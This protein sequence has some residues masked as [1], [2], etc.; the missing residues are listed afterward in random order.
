MKK[1]MFT[2]LCTLSIAGL[3]A[4]PS[5]PAHAAENAHKL[6]SIS[7]NVST[8]KITLDSNTD[9]DDILERLEA[10]GIEFNWQSLNTG[11]S[12]GIVQIIQNCTPDNTLPDD[13]D[14][15]SG[16]SNDEDT[17]PDN[18]NGG[19]TQ[20]DNGGSDNDN[21]GDTQPDKDD[22]NN[23]GNN[24]QPDNGGSNNGN[25]D[26]SS[27]NTGSEL[28]ALAA[29]VADIVNSERANAGLPALEF[30]FQLSSAAQ[31]RAEEIETYFSHTRPDGSSFSSVLAEHGISY[32]GAGE[33]IAWGQRSPSEVMTGWMNS[34]GHRANILSSRYTKIGVG[35]HQDI[36]G[37]LYWTQ[38]FTY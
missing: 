29:E 13:N 35:V 22:S 14:N 21:D 11:F 33:N 26:N 1:K 32:R 38:L 18:D 10:M 19:D 28:S 24:T 37:R 20:P 8:E 16:D 30:D 2:G 3:L 9:I 15:G 25:G 4:A 23:G 5:I 7:N 12:C 31:V 36:N 34:D 6:Q 17:Q 27:D